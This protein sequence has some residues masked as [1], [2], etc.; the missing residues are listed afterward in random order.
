MQDILFSYPGLSIK[1]ASVFDLVIDESSSAA[2]SGSG[3]AAV[4]KI[5]G[6]KLGALLV[7]FSPSSNPIV[8]NPLPWSIA[9]DLF[10]FVI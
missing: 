6:V 3:S 1:A 10:S 8:E 4:G 7:Y 5:A 2:G 9:N